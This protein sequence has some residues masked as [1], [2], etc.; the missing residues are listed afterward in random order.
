MR[1]NKQKKIDKMDRYIFLLHII[2]KAF[3]LNII[4]GENN[5]GHSIVRRN[6]N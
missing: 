3:L 4:N 6:L 1:E 5:T 2:I